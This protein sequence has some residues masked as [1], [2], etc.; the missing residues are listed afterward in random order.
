MDRKDIENV[1]G[2]S[3]LDELHL[4][5]SLDELLAVPLEAKWLALTLMRVKSPESFAVVDLVHQFSP[6]RALSLLV[7]GSVEVSAGEVVEAL[8]GAA[9]PGQRQA[10]SLLCAYALYVACFRLQTVAD[11]SPNSFAEALEQGDFL[12][13]GFRWFYLLH[14][15]R[16]AL[17]GR[18][19]IEP[20]RIGQNLHLFNLAEHGSELMES[21]QALQ[22]FV[23]SYPKALSKHADSEPFKAVLSYLDDIGAIGHLDVEFDGSE[24]VKALYS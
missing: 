10:E 13:D 11:W 20:A 17:K 9:A 15:G 16:M 6:T 8:F 19:D 24:R 21:L 23:S 4:A 14:L 22:S 1:V 3:S 5:L 7:V 12:D 18:R 2:A